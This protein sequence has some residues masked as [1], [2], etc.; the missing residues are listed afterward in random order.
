[1]ARR[2]R[3]PDLCFRASLATA[4][5]APLVNLQLHAVHLEQLLVLLHERVLRLG[6]DVDERL[7]VEL[8]QRRDH[9]QATDEL[10]DHAELEQVL[11]LHLAQQLPDLPLLLGLDLGAEADLPLA[12]APLDDLL[13]PDERAAADEQDVRRV[14]LQELL[15]RVL[16]PALGRHVAIVPS[17]ILSSACCTPSPETSR[18]MLGLS[19]LRAIL[20]ISSM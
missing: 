16:A 11:G 9:R 17:M 20:S 12:D 19:L 2:P 7:L 5:S 14:D 10:G 4:C 15:L 6:Q 8:V 3:A 13:E 1:M 18:V